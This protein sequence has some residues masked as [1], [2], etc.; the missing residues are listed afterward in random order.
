MNVDSSL[1]MEQLMTLKVIACSV[2]FIILVRRQMTLTSTVHMQAL[3]VVVCAVVTAM[4]IATLWVSTAQI[5]M[6]MMR[7]AALPA[8]CCLTLVHLVMLTA[9]QY[10]VAC[11]TQVCLPLQ[12]Q[13]LIALTPDYWAEVS[14]VTTV[15]SIVTLWKRTVTV[16]MKTVKH[17]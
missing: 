15:N 14:V 3:L 1:Q 5:A 6:A 2:V 10:S 16:L 17:V 4:S 8:R 9:I 11:I 12:M 7:H 13:R